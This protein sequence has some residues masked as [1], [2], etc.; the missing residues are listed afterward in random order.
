MSASFFLK[1]L[2]RSFEQFAVEVEADGGDLTGLLGAENI[3]GAADLEIAHGDLHAC[4]KAGRFGECMEAAAGELREF[5]GVGNEKVCVG[6]AVPSARRVRAFDRG[7]RG[8]RCRR[9]R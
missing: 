3:S 1:R 7:R 4:A 9:G 2:D 5:A 6:R 8:Q